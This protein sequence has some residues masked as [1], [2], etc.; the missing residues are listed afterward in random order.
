MRESLDKKGQSS[1]DTVDLARYI[2]MIQ[3]ITTFQFCS[4]SQCYVKLQVNAV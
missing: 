2:P 3:F 4:D 1:M